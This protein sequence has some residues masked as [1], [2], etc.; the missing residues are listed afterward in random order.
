MSLN[1]PQSI[2]LKSFSLI[3]FFILTIFLGST[4]VEAASTTWWNSSIYTSADQCPAYMEPDTGWG[5]Y[6]TPLCC[7]TLSCPNLQV[8]AATFT[9]SDGGSGVNTY[10][11]GATITVSVAAWAGGGDN[12][13][14]L[15]AISCFFL[16]CSGSP[17]VGV[18]ASFNGVSVA[19]AE[20][21]GSASFS[22]SFTAP[23]APGS[24]TINLVGCGGGISGCST[25]SI[26]FGVVAPPPSVFLQFSF[27][28]KARDILS[29][30]VHLFDTLRQTS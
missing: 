21:S 28:D 14:G 1:F 2:A 20:G 26:S 23:T 4:K 11:P 8:I 25:S 22:G 13:R 3:L 9:A 29:N 30:P 18:D 7:A 15:N 5:T 27:L 10:G 12:T 19:H 24:Y 6:G 17:G 16:G